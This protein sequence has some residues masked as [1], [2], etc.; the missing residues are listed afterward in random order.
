[1]APNPRKCQAELTDGTRCAELAT[2]LGI[3]Y[4]YTKRPSESGQVEHYLDETHYQ[5][6]CPKCGERTHVEAAD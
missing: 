5:L 6:H 3:R 1:M 2:I 4:H